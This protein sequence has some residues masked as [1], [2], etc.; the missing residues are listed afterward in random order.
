MIK[1]GTD[2]SGIE[3]PIYAIK[4]ICKIYDLKFSHI[5]SSEIC[6]YCIKYI[7][8]NHNPKIIFNDINIRKDTD[9]PYVDIYVAGFPCC[10]F[11]KANMFKS[12]TDPRLKLYEKCLKVIELVNPKFFILENVKTLLS[13]NGSYY[14]NHI[15][16]KLKEINKYSIYYKIINTKD[17]GIPQSR[18]RLYIIG[19]LNEYKKTG[20]RFPD[21]KKLLNILDFVDTTDNSKDLI[22]DKNIELFNNI[23]NDSVF[24]DIGFRKFNFVNSNKWCSCIMSSPNMWCVPMG[25]KANVKEYLM[26]QGFPT[27]VIH[28]KSNHRMKLLIGNSMSINVIEELIISGLR[29]L[30]M[31]KKI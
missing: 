25:R 15:M 24:I 22:K 9:I 12:D 4:N 30:D 11:S 16:K 29:S 17:L 10:S 8:T 23:P 3:A 20:Y 5:F 2:F 13:M 31:L 26:L 27:D 6:D 1:I 21:N 19:V 14:F 7:K 18:D 28:Q